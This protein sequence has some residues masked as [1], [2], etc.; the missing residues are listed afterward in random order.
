MK[1]YVLENKKIVSVDNVVEYLEKME[2]AE[3]NVRTTAFQKIVVSSVFVGIDFSINT[4]NRKPRIF[5]TVVFGGSYNGYKYLSTSWNS[6]LKKHRQ[7]V[8]LIKEEHHEEMQK[9]FTHIN[10]LIVK[11]GGIDTI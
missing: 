8:N 5:E 7:L 10:Q 3:T 2:K 1:L 4:K 6:T 11:I 9:G